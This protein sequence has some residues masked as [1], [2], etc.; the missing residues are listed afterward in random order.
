MPVVDNG[1]GKA[2]YLLTGF[3][4]SSVNIGDRLLFRAAFH[5]ASDGGESFY[6]V[7]QLQ[8]VPG[9]IV[10]A[11]IPGIVAACAMLFG[12]ARRRRALAA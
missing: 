11:G 7:P 10:G 5:G 2:D 3:D 12:L 8:A 6:I 9:P 1:N 4:L